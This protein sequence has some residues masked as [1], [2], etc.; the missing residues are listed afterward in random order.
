M[1]KLTNGRVIVEVPEDKAAKY[2]L[3]MGYRIMDDAPEKQ[4]EEA[5]K[6]KRGR[7]AKKAS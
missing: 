5:P 2:A 3:I 4:V 6:P 1:V 7:P